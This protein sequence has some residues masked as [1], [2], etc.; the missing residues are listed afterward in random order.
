M[1]SLTNR[2]YTPSKVRR[3][4]P[5]GRLF[6]T[7]LLG[8]LLEPVGHALAYVLR[9]GPWEAWQLQSQGDHTYFP[10]IF[11]LSAIS[12]T[13]VMALG[14][15]A[16]V[17]IR[18]IL[19]NRGVSAQGLR[20]AFLTLTLTQ[21]FL[22]GLQE[23]GEALAVQSSPDVTSIVILAISVQVPLAALAAWL[24]SWILGYVQLAPAALRA[25]LAVRLAPAGDR[26]S[27]STVPVTRAPGR[28]SR[29]ALV[30]TPRST[31]LD[32]T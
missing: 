30:S 16:V 26:P 22:F 11:S 20:S 8:A 27:A 2:V 19:G 1:K 28:S 29:P 10:G 21:C 7:F 13:V 5:T 17:S 3:P 32:L 23:T 4:F 25:V 31:A 24:L 14:L 6:A 15:I 9:Y 12:L 18:L